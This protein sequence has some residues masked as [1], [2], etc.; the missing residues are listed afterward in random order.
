[1]PVLERPAHAFAGREA[2]PDLDV[3]RRALDDVDD[4]HLVR[5]GHVG[6]L[7]R[8]RD[9]REDAER[10]DALLRLADVA[11]RGRARPTSSAMRRRTT[12]SRVSVEPVDDDRADDDLV[13]LVTSN[14]TRARVLSSDGSSVYLTST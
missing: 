2:G 4:D 1:M 14:R 10:R 8:D 11:R 12:L 13:A 6:I 9:A 3:L 5:R 7:E